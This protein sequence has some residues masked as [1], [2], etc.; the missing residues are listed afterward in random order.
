MQYF[1]A[2]L[3]FIQ[4]HLNIG[5]THIFLTL[6]F[7]WHGTAM[8][9][10]ARS[11]RSYIEEGSV[12]LTSHLD[13]GTPDLYAVMGMSFHRDNIKTFQVM[14]DKFYTPTLRYISFR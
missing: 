9:L 2:L 12:S 1:S 8:A 10:Y 11:L 14:G 5:V 3:E 6:P 13:D 7:P 4:H